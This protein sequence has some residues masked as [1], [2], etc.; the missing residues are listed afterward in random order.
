[1][2]RYT[3]SYLVNGSL[4]IIQEWIQEGFIVSSL[5][6]AELIFSL[7]DHSLLAFD[8]LEEK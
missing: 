6:L 7:A 1:M 8:P 4:A 3:Y 5:E 2:K